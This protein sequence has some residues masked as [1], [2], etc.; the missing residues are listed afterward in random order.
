MITRGSR[1]VLLYEAGW[2]DLVQLAAF[3]TIDDER[4]IDVTG[5][6]DSFCG[7][8]MVGLAMNKGMRHAAKLG[9]VSASFTI[10]GYGALY[11]LQTSGQERLAR[12][13]TL[14]NRSS[15]ID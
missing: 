10:E 6:G 2:P 12:L 8:F 15:P 7:G 14:E 11:P 1:G 3:H 5:A 4:I 9:L 13:T